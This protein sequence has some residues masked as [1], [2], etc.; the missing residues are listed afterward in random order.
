MTL[1]AQRTTQDTRGTRLCRPS[2]ALLEYYAPLY[3]WELAEKQARRSQI[4]RHRTGAVIFA[5]NGFILSKGC[6]H[7]HS[8]GLSVRSVHA[9]M[10]ALGKLPKGHFNGERCLVVSLTRCDNY[11]TSSRPCVRCAQA[12]KRKGVLVVIYAEKANDG[13]WCVNGRTPQDLLN[14]N[15]VET[16]LVKDSW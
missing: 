7:S 4:R 6:S 11:A 8:G 2:D 3:A 16:R 5:G 9:E 10:H 15:L 1:S 13:T 12:L 14:G